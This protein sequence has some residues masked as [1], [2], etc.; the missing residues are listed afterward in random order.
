[1]FWSLGRFLFIFQIL[2]WIGVQYKAETAPPEKDRQDQ[3]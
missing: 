1:M 3:V 2:K